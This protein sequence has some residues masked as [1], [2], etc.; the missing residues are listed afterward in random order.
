M[1]SRSDPSSDLSTHLGH[2]Q[3][4]LLRPR[5]QRVA[6]VRQDL[7][8]LGR[9]SYRHC[10]SHVRMAGMAGEGQEDA[11]VTSEGRRSSEARDWSCEKEGDV[12][13]CI[14]DWRALDR[15]FRL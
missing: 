8:T 14:Q 12:S 3:H 2:L 6:G 15:N 4:L 1:A 10:D 13:R 5:R 11:T 9:D 7:D